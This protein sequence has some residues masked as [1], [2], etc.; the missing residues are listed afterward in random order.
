MTA[1]KKMFLYASG[2]DSFASKH[3]R[4]NRLL[5][6][7]HWFIFFF[8]FFHLRCTQKHSLWKKASSKCHA[9]AHR[10]AT[11]M[12][13]L[14]TCPP[15]PHA[16]EEFVI[17]HMK[18]WRSSHA[19]RFTISMWTEMHA[20]ILISLQKAFV[21]VQDTFKQAIRR[22]RRSEKMKSDYIRL[23]ECAV[24]PSVSI[25]LHLDCALLSG[26]KRK[27]HWELFPVGVADEKTVLETLTH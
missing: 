7:S 21:Y 24:C 12:C 27:N 14:Q 2:Q 1:V 3:A 4:H 22:R 18:S 11:L 8:S 20:S 26:Q 9:N 5:T 17:I 25:C 6:V 15:A 10:Q 13:C 19:T 16:P 23:E